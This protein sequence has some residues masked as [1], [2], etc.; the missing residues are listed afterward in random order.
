M[1][2]RDFFRVF[3]SLG[4]RRSSAAAILLIN[5]AATVLEGAGLAILLPV[6]QFI[7]ANGD[8][9]A[10]TAQSRAWALLVNICGLVNLPVTLS[11]L[12]GASF[13]CIASRQVFVY[14]RLLYIARVS[15]ALVCDARNLAFRRF[16]RSSTAY[17]GREAV[18]GIVNDLTTE[19]RY[20]IGSLT[21]AITFVGYIILVLFY[22]G[23]M[24]VLSWAMTVAAVGVLLL[25]LVVLRRLLRRSGGL[26]RA[27]TAANQEMSAFLVERL[28]SARLVRLSGTEEAEA[29]AM[30]RLTGRQRD[31]MVVIKSILARV[32]VVME[33]IVVALGFALLY[34]GVT[35]FALRI[36]EIGLFLVIII[37]LLPVV[38]E[39]MITRQSVIAGLGSLEAVSRRLHDMEAA[40]EMPGGTRPFSELRQ[41]IRFQGV[42]FCYDGG[43]ASPALAGIDLD[44]PAG[45]MTALVGPSGSGKS[46]LIDLLPRLREPTEG[47]VLFD[48][49]PI[50]QFAL[51]GL[52]AGIAYVPQSPQLFNVTV[53]QHIRYGKPDATEAEIREAARLADAADFIE[54]LP[55]GYDTMLGEGGIR[56]SGGQR[57]RLDLARA[58]VRRAPILVLDEPTSHLDADAEAQL[59]AALRHI[60]QETKIT[61][62]I[63]GHSLGSVADADAIVVLNQ[64]RLEDIGTHDELMARRGWYAQAFTK[65]QRDGRGKEHA[66][67]PLGSSVP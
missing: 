67:L 47:A 48:G 34:V 31:T 19:V 14:A 4:F 49:S 28:K 16:L 1:T 26:S 57:Q 50:T 32:E 66:V 45:K 44:I 52:R 10:L 56:L 42:R 24:F 5:L 15:E 51:A 18:G 62:I 64:G 27:L 59:R 43:D 65:Q 60:R 39:M 23:L 63:V 29:T 46:T 37:R 40:R 30:V 7:Q 53:A 35:Y 55:K 61:L 9:A 20:A 25:S 22:L 11:T 36:E 41:G 21:S 58:L 33:P 12:L 3:D 13:L 38:K 8:I 54:A 2:T 6:F 17:Q